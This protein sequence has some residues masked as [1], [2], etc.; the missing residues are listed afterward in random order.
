MKV[1]MM[2]MSVDFVLSKKSHKFCV[3]FSLGTGDWKSHFH[4]T[5][6]LIYLPEVLLTLLWKSDDGRHYL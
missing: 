2:M 3:I 6:Y 1:K 5:A 4:Q